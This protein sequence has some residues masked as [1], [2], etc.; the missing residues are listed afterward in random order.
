MPGSRT[1]RTAVVSINASARSADGANEARGASQGQRRQKPPAGLYCP[2]RKPLAAYTFSSRLRSFKK[3]Q[4]FPAAMISCG[5]DLIK[6][7]GMHLQGLERIDSWD[8][9]PA[10]YVKG[11]TKSS[12]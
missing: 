6:P 8:C 12:K 3:R 7:V 10:I 5:F 1:S 9:A 4:P 11:S 2:H